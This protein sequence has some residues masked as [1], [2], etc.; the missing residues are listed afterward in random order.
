MHFAEFPLPIWNYRIEDHASGTGIVILQL[1]QDNSTSGSKSP[2][3]KTSNSVSNTLKNANDK[4]VKA[5]KMVK[6]SN[7]SAALANYSQWEGLDSGK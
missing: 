5:V 4:A 3:L 1:F 2:T 7:L 6:N